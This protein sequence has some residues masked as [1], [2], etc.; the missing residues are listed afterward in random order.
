MPSSFSSL[1]LSLS[2]CLTAP[3]FF[4]LL[5]A[6]Q[7]QWRHCL[8]VPALYNLALVINCFYY[9]NSN[10]LSHLIGFAVLLTVT[11]NVCNGSI[12]L[13]SMFYATVY[14]Y[15]ALLLHKASASHQPQPVYFRGH[16]QVLY[17]SN[18][19]LAMLLL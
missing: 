18:Y 19:S 6:P 13:D 8:F 7:R 2:L 3:K 15:V 5:R 4:R 14:N 1:S 9:Y 16:S 12:I 10:S 17:C 11:I